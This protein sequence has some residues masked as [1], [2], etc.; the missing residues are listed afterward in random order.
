MRGFLGL[1]LFFTLQTITAQVSDKQE[2]IKK[3]ASYSNKLLEQGKTDSSLIIL[4]KA[5]NLAGN[6][7]DSV[8]LTSLNRQL[9]QVF[10]IKG[11]YKSSL[12]H[13]YNAITL[14]HKTGQ[15]VEL[16]HCFAGVS[17]VYFRTGNY[18]LSLDNGIK[19]AQIYKQLKDTTDYIKSME[20]QAQVYQGLK[21]YN[22]S[23]IIYKEMLLLS[24]RL[25]IALILFTTQNI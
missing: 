15:S 21:K 10:E 11:D 2:L 3:Y 25:G 6:T 9:G 8:W 19:S 22:E 24:L 4:Y 18:E 16:A 5:I 1:I 12:K 23:L 14:A 20:L 13:Y 7:N 17:N